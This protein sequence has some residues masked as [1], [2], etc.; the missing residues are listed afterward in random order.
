MHKL[1]LPSVN[2]TFKA[3]QLKGKNKQTQIKGEVE[4]PLAFLQ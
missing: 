4:N 2:I 1:K 3:I